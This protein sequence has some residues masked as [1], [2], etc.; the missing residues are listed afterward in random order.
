L[1][2][3]EPR[4]IARPRGT[5]QSS[6][7]SEVMRIMNR[8]ILLGA[9]SA[10]AIGGGAALAD[11]RTEA[12]IGDEAAVPA[13]GEGAILVEVGPADPVMINENDFGTAAE[14]LA[15]MTAGEIEGME[16]FDETGDRIGTVRMVTE[17]HAG[18]IYLIVSA[19]ES[20]ATVMA[21][22]H[23][24][25][26]PRF[27]YDAEADA[28]VMWGAYATSAATPDPYGTRAR[29]YTA[30]SA[31]AEVPQVSADAY[32]MPAE[33]VD[34]GQ[35]DLAE[36]EGEPAIESAET[37][38]RD[39]TVD[40]IVG[41][42]ILDRHG[43]DVGD[44]EVVAH[45]DDQLYLIVSLDD[46]ILGIGDSERAVK[47]DSFDYSLPDEAFVLMDTSKDTLEAM[48]EYDSDTPGYTVIDSDLDW[49][50]FK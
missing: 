33:P 6:N 15:G 34:E 27:D 16:V 35:E 31:D 36:M 47:L 28:L 29:L 13:A 18:G 50:R 38:V 7:G 21:G 42:D 45:A 17:G 4:A 37:A 23:A 11:D 40:E 8:S 24:V 5:T 12:V 3:Y 2:L 9:A 46:G 32:R 14:R 25:P 43:E 39:W 48:P 49:A 10:L 22:D 1:F 19:E 26:L 30:L 41:R 20:S 44:V